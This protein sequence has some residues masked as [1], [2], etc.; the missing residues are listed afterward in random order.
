MIKKFQNIHRLFPKCANLNRAADKRYP[1][2]VSWMVNPEAFPIPQKWDHYGYGSLANE[3][4]QRLRHGSP[5][6]IVDNETISNDDVLIGKRIC[7]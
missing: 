2:Q 1:R 6:A 4:V 3:T 5:Q 7:T